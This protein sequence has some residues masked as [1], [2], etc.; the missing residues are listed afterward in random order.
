MYASADVISSMAGLAIA[1][2]EVEQLVERLG[3]PDTWDT[4]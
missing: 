2:D 1:R 4:S 3:F